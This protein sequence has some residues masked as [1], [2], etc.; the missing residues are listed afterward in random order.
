VGT[1]IDTAT[2]GKA[3]VLFPIS[4]SEM[5]AIY[6]TNVAAGAAGNAF[7]RAALFTFASAADTA[8]TATDLPGYVPAPLASAAGIAY[9]LYVCH[10]TQTDPTSPRTYIFA[11]ATIAAAFSV[12]QHEGTGTALA[13]SPGAADPTN[14]ALP[15]GNDTVG[16][17]R[18]TLTADDVIEDDVSW[19]TSASAGRMTID[20]TV[21]VES[22]TYTFKLWIK[23][24]GYWLWAQ[25]TLAGTATGGTRS[26]NEVNGL[27]DNTSMTVDV[28][29]TAMS[30]ADGSLADWQACYY[31]E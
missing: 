9:L 19:S 28:D 20:A 14:Y 12:A 18:F 16:G 21:Q 3:A 4:D 5:L 13:F 11:A 6:A 17:S 25:A 22:G 23:P 29:F 8:P 7:Y 2:A 26:G 10:D 1:N 31:R 15:F 24:A 30:Y 27:A